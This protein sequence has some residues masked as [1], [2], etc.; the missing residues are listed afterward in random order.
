MAFEL[1]GAYPK[2]LDITVTTI[3]E[4]YKAGEVSL[5]QAVYLIGHLVTAAAIDNKVEVQAWMDPERVKRW[6]KECAD[7]NGA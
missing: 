2:Q 4:A 7:A 3:L 6:K 1:K 5:A